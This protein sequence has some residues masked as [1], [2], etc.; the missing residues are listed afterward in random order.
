[1]KI[2]LIWSCLKNGYLGQHFCTK[3]F[4]FSRESEEKKTEE[5]RDTNK[6]KRF[7]KTS[8][9]SANS[10]LKETKQKQ[11]DYCPLAD[12]THEIWNCLLFRN[13]SVNDRYAAL[14][15]QR[16][17]YGSLGKGHAVKDCIVNEC[18]I[19]G[20]IKKHNR[21]LHSENQMDED[22]HVSQRS[23]KLTSDSSCLNTE[24]WQEAEHLHFPRQWVND[25]IHRSKCARE[26]TSPRHRCDAQHSWHTRNKGSEDRKHS[27]QN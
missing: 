21:L 6:D 15:K 19:K 8:N 18:G 9:F 2:G 23:Y 22:N 3:G 1:M 26:T 17:C 5:T 16:F 24:R 10:N 4:Q 11:S 25:F 27:S 20:C 14:R 13:M 12:G 7:S